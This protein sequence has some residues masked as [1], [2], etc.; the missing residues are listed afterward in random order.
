MKYALITGGTKGIGKA[1][2]AK[3][4]TEGY[5][6]ILNYANNDE[7]AWATYEELDT[8]YPNLVTLL[9]D[10]SKI[11]NIESLCEKIYK[12]TPVLD[13][14]ILNAGKTDRSGFKDIKLEAWQDVFNTNVT[15]PFFIVQQLVSKM[16]A[17]G[18]VLFTGSLMGVYPHS[19]SITYGITKSAIH[20]L[21]ENLVK[22]FVDFK[23]RVNAIIPGFVDTEWQLSKPDY[24][25]ESITNKIALGRFATTEEIA[26]AAMF[27]IKNTYMNGELL[28]IDGGYCYK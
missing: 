11:N 3:L 25:R 23:L 15:I 26:D 6:I 21:V 19:L 10:L 4:L 5:H 20:S 17:G 9:K 24:I 16:N 18:T 12:I 1:I 14:L 13:A 27:L 28:V 7:M 2:G 8:T 22:N